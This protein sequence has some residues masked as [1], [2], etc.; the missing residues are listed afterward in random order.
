MT[1][2]ELSAAHSAAIRRH[3]RDLDDAGG[4]AGPGLLAS[5][6]A[7]AGQHA[8]DIG[9]I[10]VKRED[11]LPTDEQVGAWIRDHPGEVA[12][13]LAAQQQAAPLIAPGATDRKGPIRPRSRA[14][15]PKAG[16]S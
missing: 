1:P 5:L 15:R 10:A 14:A 3:W 7:V 4:I 6:A 11:D 2:D 9:V 12:A 16:G 8:A 13:L